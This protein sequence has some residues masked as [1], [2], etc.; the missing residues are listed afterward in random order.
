MTQPAPGE[1]GVGGWRS[2]ARSLLVGYFAVA[3]VL[4]A[5]TTLCVI[6]N[7]GWRE[8]MFDQW[9]EYEV[10]LGLPFPQNVLQMMNGHRPILPNLVRVAEVRW[11]DANQVLQLTVGALAA[12]L[13]AGALAFAA[14]REPGMGRVARMAG[15][16]LAVIGLLWLGNARR[17]LHGSEALNGYLPTLGAI[18]A[19]LCVHRAS[20]RDSRGWLVAACVACVLAT[21]SFGPGLASFCAV[22]GAGVLLRMPWRQLALP[23]AVSLASLLAYVFVLPGDTGVREQLQIEPFSAVRLLAEWIASTWK[24]AWFD[25]ADMPVAGR[26]LSAMVKSALAVSARAATVGIG[27]DVNG[28]CTVLGMAGIGL[29]V[30]LLLRIFWRREAATRLEIVAA[31][32]GLYA[33]ASGFIT[34][35]A[36]LR[37]LHDLPEQVYADRYLLWPSLFWCALAL[38][39]VRRLDR[40]RL[41][42]FAL[43]PILVAT[44]LVF[45][46]TQNNG[47]IWGVL[48]HREAEKTAAAVR[49]GIYDK[50]HFTGE[51]TGDEAHLREIA[52]LRDG[53]L[54]MFADPSWQRLGTQWTGTL[55]T[56]S[57]ISVRTRWL[58]PVT[59]QVAMAPAGH[60]EGWITRGIAPARR[61][62]ELVV[63]SEDGH[64]IVGFA[65]F[66]FVVP[67]VRPLRLAI[68]RKRGF[69]AF[70]RHYDAG[71]PYV[72]AVADFSANRAIELATMPAVAPTA[73]AA[74]ASPAGQ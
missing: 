4:F 54:A 24:T 34:V 72:L 18:C 25:L 61:F 17:L 73:P 3:A 49:S 7:F 38:L 13:S 30:A 14:W 67:E 71:R 5:L 47:A 1:R 41:V 39:V 40:T 56:S 55:E 69:D 46:I 58:E 28:W 43:V 60:I 16:M 65:N 19:V 21:F 37:Y 6:I 70:V 44:P 29:F 11:F 10:L 2:L 32:T 9:R 8:P 50:D 64:E 35:V 62:G 26:G 52:L 22:L 63:L 45:A 23:L 57:E 68:P 48:V 74:A 66:S 42:A 53:R 31:G 12:F 59:D 36:R 33:L 27:A 51:A 15:V 20:R